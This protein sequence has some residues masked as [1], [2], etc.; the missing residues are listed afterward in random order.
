M[1]QHFIL[2]LVDAVFLQHHLLLN[3]PDFDRLIIRTAGA[4]ILLVIMS[5][6]WEARNSFGVTPEFTWV[7]R[8]E[9]NH[10]D[11]TARMNLDKPQSQGSFIPSTAAEDALTCSR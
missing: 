10:D 3:V 5:A 6:K 11:Q 1:S 7:G 2:Y 9:D 4:N 8:K